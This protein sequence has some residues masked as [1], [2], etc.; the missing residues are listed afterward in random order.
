M[1]VRFAPEYAVIVTNGAGSSTKSEFSYDGVFRRRVRKEYTW[2][3]GT[4]NLASEVRY[5][6][7]GRLA[8]QERDG[9]NVPTVTFTR[10]LDLSGSREGAGGIGGLLARTDHATGQSA[11]YHADG[12][13]NVTALVN[14]QQLVVA[15]Y[16]YDPFG[17]TLSKS[18]PLA[19]ANLYRFSSKESHQPSGLAY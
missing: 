5:V 14:A 18:G 4:W 6:Y 11:F 7:E 3:S 1:G 19:D 2:S 10:G 8:L 9:N 17:N 13:G 12:N 15:R 16:T